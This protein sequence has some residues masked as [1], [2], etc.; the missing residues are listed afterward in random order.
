MNELIARVENQ[1]KRKIEDDNRR[2]IEARYQAM[3]SMAEGVFLVDMNN[4][5]LTSN[6]SAVKLLGVSPGDI[7]ETFPKDKNGKAIHEN[8][9]ELKME[10]NPILITL[11]TGKSFSNYV[12]GIQKPEENYI[13]WIA[14]NTRP[15]IHTG[16]SQPY[17]VVTSFADISEQKRIE[18]ALRDSEGRF[19]ALTVSSPVAIFILQNEK[20]VYVNPAF[21]KICGYSIN[22]ISNI[23][24]WDIIHPDM[25]EKARQRIQAW[26]SGESD[27]GRDEYRILTKY[28]EERWVDISVT[29]MEYRGK[30]AMMGTGI[31]ITSHK[32]A[33]DG[34]WEARLAANLGSLAA[35]VASEISQPLEAAESASKVLIDNTHDFAKRYLSGAYI[36]SE[37]DQYLR[38]VAESVM[39][40]STKLKSVSELI[41]GY[42]NLSKDQSMHI[43][44]I[45]DIKEFLNEIVSNL[46]SKFKDARY[47]IQIN[48][49][50]HL[51]VQTY[52]DTFMQVITTLITNSFVHGFSGKEQGTIVI[53]I[54]KEMSILRIVY[55]DDGHGMDEVQ[56]KKNFNPSNAIQANLK[57][58][59]FGMYIVYNMVT[60]VLNGIIEC[61]SQQGSGTT[62]TIQIPIG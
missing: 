9:I 58:N 10:D 12:I 60:S 59:G 27:T 18:G 3:M 39:L 4:R 25:L 57:G 55:H 33:A 47:S 46:P 7:L 5:I 44:R 53:D 29:A 8:G 11:R 40:I 50:E 13:T 1:I 30:P 21:E 45:F 62:Y 36:K 31:N 52:A 49:P 38:L 17:A 23:S 28:H 56:V 43:K 54:K 34:L 35:G 14:L 51:I 61:S 24:M 19:R 2:E 16:D 32:T 6:P 41:H 37:I 26:Y 42:E 20:F 15:L 22:E 48:C